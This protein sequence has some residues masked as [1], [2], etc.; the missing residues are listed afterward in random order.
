MSIDIESHGD[1][2]PHLNV[3]ACQ[4]VGSENVENHLLGI[5][6]MSLNNEALSLPFTTSRNTAPLRHS[7]YNLSL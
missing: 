4:A 6:V 1:F 7:G 2:L 3:E 5:C